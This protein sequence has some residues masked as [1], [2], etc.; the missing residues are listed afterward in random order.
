MKSRDPRADL[1][2][3]IERV[4]NGLRAVRGLLPGKRPEAVVVEIAGAYPAR[5]PRRPFF[6]L[7]LPAELGMQQASLEELT[8]DL[9]ALAQAR[10]VKRVVFRIGS[11][12][13]P[14]LATAWALRRAVAAVRAAGSAPPRCS[15]TST[16][17]RTTWLRPRRRWSS[18]RAPTSG[19]TAWR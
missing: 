18:P 16:P 6:G 1:E 7:P 5:T 15:R 3:K 12:R 8:R 9:R 19:S 13:A 4:R 2:R 14:R 10:S 17:P 11:L